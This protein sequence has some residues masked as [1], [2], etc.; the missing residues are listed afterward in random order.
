MKLIGIVSSHSTQQSHSEFAVGIHR[1]RRNVKEPSS[2]SV[3]HAV[4]Q[5]F[6]KRGV[7]TE[8]FVIKLFNRKSWHMT[9][10]IQQLKAEDRLRLRLRLRLRDWILGVRTQPEVLFLVLIFILQAGFWLSE[11]PRGV[12]DLL[13]RKCLLIYG[14]VKLYGSHHQY[15]PAHSTVLGCPEFLRKAL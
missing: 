6:F 3:L 10:V 4:F 9:A 1:K 2:I 8:G 12:Q 5:L 11:F 14:Q 15:T 13:A 7:Q